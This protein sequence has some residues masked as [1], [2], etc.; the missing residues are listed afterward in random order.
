[1][2]LLFF[3]CAKEDE[4]SDLTSSSS[5]DYSKL[6]S[7]CFSPYATAPQIGPGNEFFTVD[8][9]NNKRESTWG[10][11]HV[12]KVDGQFIMFASSLPNDRADDTVEHI[13][14]YRLTSSNGRNWTLNPTSPVL[15][16]TGGATWDADGV[17]TPSVVFYKNEYHMFY[18]SYPS[19]F[20]AS[21]TYRIGHA[22]SSNG[23]SWTRVTIASPLVAPTDPGNTTALLTFNQWVTAEPGAV[24][25]NDKIYLYYAATGSNTEA[26]ST[27]EVIG[28][29]TY[30]GS[31]WS[32][33][34]EVMRADQAVYPRLTSPYYKGFSTPAATVIDNKVHLFTTAVIQKDDQ[35]VGYKHT[36]I[37][38]AYSVNGEDNWVQDTTAITDYQDLSWH[39]YDLISPTAL[40]DGNTVYLWHGG[41]NGS[42]S[43]L[44]IGLMTCEL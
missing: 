23:I 22:K 8:T 31:T 7:E 20:S 29:I 30:D 37:H 10:D 13:A 44:G 5:P 15:E 33:Q 41:N 6:K 34:Q 25:F 9:G 3:S 18:T 42:L 14:V 40:L 24:V 4:D 39:N 36:K 11:P 26:A 12:L 32:A 16:R 38:H 43:G 19:D 1:M 21:T 27:A 35:G 17:E 2:F 28:L